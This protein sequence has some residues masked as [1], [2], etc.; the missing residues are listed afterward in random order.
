[1]KK[2]KK[3]PSLKRKAVVPFGATNPEGFQTDSGQRGLLPREEHIRLHQ[4]KLEKGFC[5]YWRD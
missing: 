4:R 5:P 3:N 1:M 2:E